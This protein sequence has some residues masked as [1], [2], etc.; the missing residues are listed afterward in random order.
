[1]KRSPSLQRLIDLDWQTKCSKTAMRPDY[2]PKTAFIDTTANGLTKCIVA[3][4]RLNG[5]RADRVSSAGRYIDTS[6][7]VTNVIGHTRTIKDGKF[8]PSQ[9]SRGYADINATIKGRSVMIEV[10]M[11]DKMSEHQ[12]KFAEAERAAGGQYWV[13]HSF[14]EFMDYYEPFVKVLN[15]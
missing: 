3:W 7:T 5:G 10:K 12:K 15:N 4:I 14:E 2:V 6:Y 11:K 8:V 1:M 13:V 9:T